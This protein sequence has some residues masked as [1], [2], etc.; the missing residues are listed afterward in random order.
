M[1]HFPLQN[2]PSSECRLWVQKGQEVEV[3]F[4]SRRQQIQVDGGSCPDHQDREDPQR[5]L[6]LLPLPLVPP[7]SPV[8]LL[9]LRQAGE[10]AEVADV[11][12]VRGGG[13]DV[14]QQRNI[15]AQC[16][17]SS[18]SYQGI[19]EGNWEPLGLQQLSHQGKEDQ[20]HGGPQEAVEQD[21][22]RVFRKQLGDLDEI[23]LSG[24]QRRSWH[25]WREERPW[26]IITLRWERRRQWVM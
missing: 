8:P 22:V 18:L 19:Q 23:C 9:Q 12:H 3:S 17:H 5:W 21:K 2:G 7:L 25:S 24:A 26:A 14:Q 16:Q 15:S 1:R 11:P 10:V 13:E 6:H 20:A 4:S